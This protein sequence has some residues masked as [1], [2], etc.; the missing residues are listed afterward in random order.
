MQEPHQRHENEEKLTG[1][2]IRLGGNGAARRERPHGKLYRW[3]DNYWYHHKWKTIIIAFFLIVF[4]VCTVQMCSKAP[5]TDVNILIAGPTN[6]INEPEGTSELEALFSSCVLTDY[7]GDGSKN[8]SLRF[9]TVLSEDQIKTIEAT[10]AEDGANLQV[11]H[12]AVSDN[13]KNFYSYLRTGETAVL[14]LD[15]WVFDKVCADGLLVDLSSQLASVPEG[16]IA[17]EGS[18]SYYGIKLKETELYRTRGHMIL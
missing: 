6:F 2:D 13:Y 17:V 12:A 18:G 10:P 16:A 14:I 4:I 7:N 8:A 1:G 11:D 9:Y 5:E 3:F 15:R